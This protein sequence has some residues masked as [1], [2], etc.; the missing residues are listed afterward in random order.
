MWIV[1]HGWIISSV[2]CRSLISDSIGIL[3][4]AFWLRITVLMVRSEWTYWIDWMMTDVKSECRKKIF[5]IHMYMWN[6]NFDSCK[7]QRSPKNYLKKYPKIVELNLNYLFSCVH[8]MFELFA[9]FQ[10]KYIT[11]YKCIYASFFRLTFTISSCPFQTNIQFFWFETICDG[12][13][14]K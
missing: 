8:L 3:C 4:Q 14:L 13:T 12:S 5:K 10:H 7:N 1:N 6:V 2:I 9:D 11:I